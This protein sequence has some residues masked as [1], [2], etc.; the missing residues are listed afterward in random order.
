MSS[1]PKIMV[2]RLK[3]LISAAVFILLAILFIL[4]LIFLMTGKEKSTEAQEST[5]YN[6]GTYT[7]SLIL[8]S[9]PMEVCVSVDENYIKSVSLMHIDESVSAMY[10]L[11]EPSMKDIENYLITN[12]TL[13]NIY[14]DNDNS[15]TGTVLAGAVQTALNKACTN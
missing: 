3:E 7:A 14:F 9:M 12:Q 2:F 13:E 4:F 5:T 6:P 11:L 10:P 1:N 15:Y 8:N